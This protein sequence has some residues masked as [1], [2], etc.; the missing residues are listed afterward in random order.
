MSTTGSIAAEARTAR[1]ERSTSESSVLVEINLDGTGISDI[2]TSVPFYDHM[3][4]ALCKHCLLYTSDAA[5]E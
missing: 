5:D 2:S 1:M 4:T 3:L